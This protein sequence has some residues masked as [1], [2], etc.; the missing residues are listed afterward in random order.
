M[1]EGRSK[2]GESQTRGE[3]C[4]KHRKDW[5]RYWEE[6][7]A[8]HKTPTLYVQTR[9]RYSRAIRERTMIFNIINNKVCKRLAWVA[10]NVQTIQKV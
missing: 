6:K 5:T 2:E 7:L 4:T 3:K 10:D 8:F 1:R 9:M